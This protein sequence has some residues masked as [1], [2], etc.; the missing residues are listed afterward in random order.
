MGRHLDEVAGD[1]SG[2][3]GYIWDTNMFCIRFGGV[4]VCVCVCVCVHVCAHQ[5]MRAYVFMCE[6][7]H[8]RV[9]QCFLCLI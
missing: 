1:M 8:M 7:M 6:H 2:M 5:C 9:F 4:C 3:D